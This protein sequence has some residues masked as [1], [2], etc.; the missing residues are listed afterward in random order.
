MDTIFNS[1]IPKVSFN[2]LIQSQDTVSMFNSRRFFIEDYPT[3]VIQS[4]KDTLKNKSMQS[5]QSKE[6][7]LVNI[8]PQNS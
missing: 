7:N 1:I 5:L 4:V 8:I 6:N 3:D 2:A